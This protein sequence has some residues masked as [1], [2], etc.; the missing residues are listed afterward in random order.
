MKE[1]LPIPYPVTNVDF[2]KY[3][4]SKSKLE[5]GKV[6]SYSTFMFIRLLYFLNNLIQ[7]SKNL[8]IDFVS[9]FA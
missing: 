6:K 1:I 3:A 5:G 2:K 4:R 8:K 9:K 7:K